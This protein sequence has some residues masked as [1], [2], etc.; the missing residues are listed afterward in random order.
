MNRLWSSIFGARCFA[1]CFGMRIMKNNSNGETYIDWGSNMLPNSLIRVPDFSSNSGMV[2]LFWH[3]KRRSRATPELEWN[4]PPFKFK[5]SICWY[6]WNIWHEHSQAR[7]SY[8]VFYKGS[9]ALLT[10]RSLERIHNIM[11]KSYLS[12]FRTQINSNVSVYY[13]NILK[14]YPRSCK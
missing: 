11:H 13:S 10:L 9:P 1:I 5:K 2:R 8:R 12:R 14:K 4:K 6:V 3:K 7:I